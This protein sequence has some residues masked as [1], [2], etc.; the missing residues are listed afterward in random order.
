[1]RSLYSP[2]LP[3]QLLWV[4]MSAHTQT[5]GAPWV[6]ETCHRSKRMSLLRGG[7]EA[8]VSTGKEQSWPRLDLGWPRSSLVCREFLLTGLS[9]FWMSPSAKSSH[10]PRLWLRK[11]VFSWKE[12][13]NQHSGI[14]E[15]V[16]VAWDSKLRAIRCPS[17]SQC[18]ADLEP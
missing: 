14:C 3:G 12:M 13:G 8:H 15:T 16:N 18:P 6:T 4:G 7:M 2:R 10:L 11:Q 5:G 17:L 1:M 9:C